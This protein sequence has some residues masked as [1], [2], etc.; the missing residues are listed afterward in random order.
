MTE[1][2]YIYSGVSVTQEMWDEIIKCHVKMLKFIEK[3]KQVDLSKLLPIEDK[4][5]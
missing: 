1:K 4:D 5:G 3:R 2:E